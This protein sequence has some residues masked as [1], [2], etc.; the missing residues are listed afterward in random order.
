MTLPPWRRV[1]QS[2]WRWLQSKRPLWTKLAWGILGLI[3]ALILVS[4]LRGLEA[5]SHRDAPTDGVLVLGGSIRREMYSAQYARSHPQIPILI[6]TGS[7]PPCIYLI[8]ERDNAPMDRV[9]LENCAYST[10]YNFFYS[11]PILE[12]WQVHHVELITSASHLPRAIWMARIS[13]GLHGIWVEANIVPE[14]GRPGN[15]ESRLKTLLDVTRTGLWAVVSQI[16]SPSCDQL[17]PLSQ[18]DL[19]YWATK[20]FHCEHQGQVDWQP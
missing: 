4:G 15:Q 14:I 7:L 19:D 18:V 20:G 1:P 17:T 9:W 2:I 3:L 13:L 6:S 8:F 16:H 5:L 12:R 10:F 11:L